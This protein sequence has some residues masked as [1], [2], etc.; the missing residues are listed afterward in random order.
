[1]GLHLAARQRPHPVYGACDPSSKFADHDLTPFMGRFLIGRCEAVSGSNVLLHRTK[2]VNFGLKHAWRMIWL[3]F[4]PA[5]L[6]F[7]KGSHP[8][9][10]EVIFNLAPFMGSLSVTSPRFVLVGSKLLLLLQQCSLSM[11]PFLFTLV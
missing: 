4:N 11:P 7:S 6:G 9:Y 1:M 8:V 3:C 2:S 10:G 5:G